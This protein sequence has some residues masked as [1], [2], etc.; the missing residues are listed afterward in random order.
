MARSSFWVQDGLKHNAIST[1]LAA[2]VQIGLG[3]LN[4]ALADK[5]DE[6]ASFSF[7]DLYYLPGYQKGGTRAGVI[8][9]STTDDVTILLET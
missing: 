5:F 3:A 2:A 8:T 7:S 9:G 6:L 1:R 4:V